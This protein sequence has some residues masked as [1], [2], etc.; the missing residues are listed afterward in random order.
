M[1]NLAE[2]NFEEIVSTFIENVNSFVESNKV[3][4]WIK[5]FLDLIKQFSNDIAVSFM[6]LESNLGV[7]KA[8]TDALSIDRD[9]ILEDLHEEKKKLENQCQYS[10]RNQLII[11]G[12]DE[13]NAAENTTD[14]VLAIFKGMDITNI[15]KTD[16]NRSHRLG[17]KLIGSPGGREK[18]RPIIVSFISYEHK[19]LV[20]DAKKKLKGKGTVVTESLTTSRYAL[21]KKCNEKYGR[22]NCWTY[23]GRIFFKQG[24]VKTCVTHED[25][26]KDF[27]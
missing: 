22:E 12:V 7:Q 6:E 3:P 17:K 10:R 16:I 15:S 26:I 19:K 18:K 20:Y 4:A 14:T 11:H 21:L 13:K 25:D 24:T 9:R 2:N 1:S 23:D 8:V 27:E 5:P